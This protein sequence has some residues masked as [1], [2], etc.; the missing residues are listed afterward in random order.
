MKT[1]DQNQ[2]CF[3]II[4]IHMVTKIGNVCFNNTRLD[5]VYMYILH[6][7]VYIFTHDHEYISLFS[8]CHSIFRPQDKSM[9]VIEKDF[10]FSQ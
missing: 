3:E 8:Q 9:H 4:S 10:F 7:H 6:T 5:T 2:N 1:A